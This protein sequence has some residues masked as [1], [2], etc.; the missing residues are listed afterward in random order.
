[1]TEGYAEYCIIDT[2]RAYS[3]ESA[4]M[5]VTLQR[6]VAAHA[7][8]CQKRDDIVHFDFH[9]NNILIEGDRVTSVIDWTVRRVA[10]A[11]STSQR[12]FSTP[13]RS[14]IFAARFGA[15]YSNER[16]AAPLEFISRT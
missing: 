3:N 6:I 10:T 1:V 12:C 11:P 4:A 5:L 13:G 16:R 2:L 15:R 9:T 8:E 7:R 14:R